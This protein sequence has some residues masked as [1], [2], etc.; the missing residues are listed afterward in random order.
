M[1]MISAMTQYASK[2]PKNLMDFAFIFIGLRRTQLKV[3]QWHW[4][5]LI[6]FN[7]FHCIFKVIIYKELKQ[8]RS[9]KHIDNLFHNYMI[10]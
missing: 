5:E 3:F 10:L 4:P 6:L 8:I 7:Y 2:C 1:Q 9:M